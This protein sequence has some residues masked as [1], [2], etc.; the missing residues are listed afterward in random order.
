M[1]KDRCPLDTGEQ[2]A[3]RP[4]VGRKNN[5]VFRARAQLALGQ[6]RFE[7]I[8]GERRQTWS[9]WINADDGGLLVYSSCSRFNSRVNRSSERR[10]SNIGCVFSSRSLQ[11]RSLYALSSHANA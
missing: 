6:P 2:L 9:Q 1:R 4:A 3:E 5:L 11:S 7:D 10:L 8:S